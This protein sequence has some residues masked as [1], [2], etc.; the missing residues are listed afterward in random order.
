[1]KNFRN[2][3]VKR[4]IPLGVYLI[5]IGVSLR[6]ALVEFTLQSGDT[7]QE[8]VLYLEY[9]KAG[10]W[11]PI[12]DSMQASCLMTTYIPSVIQKITGIDP[13]ILF[14]LI[15]SLLM[16]V[17]PVVVYYI[18]RLYVDNKWAVLSA[19]FVMCQVCF[20]R[21]MVY[22]RNNIAMVF[23]SLIILAVLNKNWKWSIKAPIIFVSVIGMVISH[24]S[25]TYTVIAW[26]IGGAILLSIVLVIK[27]LNW[28]PVVMLVCV[29]I[30]LFMASFVW[31][32]RITDVPATYAE[33]V[34]AAATK[35]IIGGVATLPSGQ[36]ILLEYEN[37]DSVV[38]AA[39]GVGF[40]ERNAPQKIE[41]IISWVT[42]L[43]LT[44]GIA[45]Y[46]YKVVK[47]QPVDYL[48][49]SLAVV[50]YLGVV[51]AVLVP[52]ISRFIGIARIYYT[53]AI[54]FAV[55][56]SIGSKILFK[57][58]PI[59]CASLVLIVYG[60]CTSGMMHLIFGVSRV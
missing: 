19:V 49:L 25:V 59:W 24:Y 27:R 33:K 18:A 47:K 28:R 11:Y 60:L 29:A 6:S 40:W 57:W 43:L 21:S 39:F 51:L 45:Y 42:I 15:P 23:V 2:D 54:I 44:V 9:L 10:R 34:L 4:L 55:F 56:Y 1:M 31:L 53:V 16:A 8:Y 37:K 13:Y 17:I 52:S 41:F 14:L 22:A 12:A 30:L 50:G 20:Q 35:D 36:T 5:G 38:A 58:K 26:L 46:C 32:D 3:L 48:L 7:S